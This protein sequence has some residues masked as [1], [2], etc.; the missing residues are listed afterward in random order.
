MVSAS[1]ANPGTSALVAT[2]TFA[3]ASQNDSTLQVI[4][5]FIK[6]FIIFIYRSNIT[7]IEITPGIFG[8]LIA[9][10]LDN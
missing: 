3:S 8:N 4:Y 9:I 5:C 1:V 10:A 6:R 2:Q 7:H